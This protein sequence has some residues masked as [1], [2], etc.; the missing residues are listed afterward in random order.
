[1]ATAQ[2]TRSSITLKGSTEIVTEF[3]GYGIN[4]ILY[5]RGIYPP[6]QFER[7]QKYGLTMLV[8]SD[9]SLKAYM[10][11]ILAQLHSTPCLF[12]PGPCMASMPDRRYRS[13]AAAKDGEEGYRRHHGR[14][15]GRH[16]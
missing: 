15:D 16:H 7:K 9:E 4:S 8:T 6:E 13:V 3:F 5:Q 14:G 1:M 11:N 10:R 12:S 2:G